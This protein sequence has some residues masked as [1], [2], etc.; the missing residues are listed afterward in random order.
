MIKQDSKKSVSREFFH[1]E[2]YQNHEVELNRPDII[3]IMKFIKR[4]FIKTGRLLEIGCADGALGYSIIQAGWHVDGIELSE[5][6]ANIARKKGL[7]VFVANVEDSIPIDSNMYDIVVAGEVIEHIFDTDY[8]LREIHRVLK[9]R[10][11]FIVTTPNLASITNRLFLLFGKYPRFVE[12]RV[13]KESAGHIRYYTFKKLIE[14]LVEN[15]FIILKKQSPN[16][17]MPMSRVPNLLKK[18]AMI[19]GDIFPTLGSH[20]IVICRKTV[21]QKEG[22]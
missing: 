21:D 3:K 14:Q 12:Y 10:G 1:S 20:I 17:L 15:D 18:I 8:F 16:I 7:D 19:F 13:S 5:K 22:C 2:V 9:K 11:I 6:A 4:N